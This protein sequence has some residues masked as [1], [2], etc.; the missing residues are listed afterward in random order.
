MKLAQ[1]RPAP[2][3]T[4]PSNALE[5]IEPPGAREIKIITDRLEG[6]RKNGNSL[7]LLRIH[8][9]MHAVGLGEKPKGEDITKFN[10]EYNM[11]RT[12]ESG[13]SLCE[14]QFMMASLGMG[15]DLTDDVRGVIR[16]SLSE[17]RRD[18]RGFHIARQHH[19]MKEAGVKSEI[20]KRDRER[21]L[22]DLEFISKNWDEREKY[23]MIMWMDSIGVEVPDRA[24]A[25][26]QMMQHHIKSIRE[27]DG[28]EA[29]L[30]RYLL[31]KMLKPQEKTN[32]VPEMPPLKKLT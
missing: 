1:A 25:I 3:L 24:D 30:T 12:N 2:L 5:L 9:M 21:I 8:H 22:K 20:T 4:P 27:G 19:F 10:G 14:V 6:E 32:E 18:F 17:T 31:T 28:G 23:K 11:D 26:E 29:L 16:K 13:T 15:R 7:D